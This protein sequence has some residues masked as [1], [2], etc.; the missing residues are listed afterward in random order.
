MRKLYKS[1]LTDA[2]WDFVRPILP[3]I[4]AKNG[5]PPTDLREVINTILYQ[6][7]IGVPWENYPCKGYLTPAE[8]E[9]VHNQTHR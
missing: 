1:D 5:F 6:T 2:Q 4:R 7:R 9:R 3:P 8:Y